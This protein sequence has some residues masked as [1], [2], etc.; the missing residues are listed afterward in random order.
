MVKFFCIVFMYTPKYEDLD[1]F[2][3]KFDIIHKD[4][5]KKNK[6]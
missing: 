2:L 6:F 3:Q 1:A 4:F 5:K